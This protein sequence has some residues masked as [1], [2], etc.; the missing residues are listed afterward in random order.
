MINQATERL[1]HDDRCLS[2]EPAIAGNPQLHDI[3]SRKHLTFERLYGRYYLSRLAY[4]KPYVNLYFKQ[5]FP[6]KFSK[7]NLYFKQFFLILTRKSR[8]NSLFSPNRVY[9]DYHYNHA[10]TFVI[11]SLND[12]YNTSIR[13]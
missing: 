9:Y 3:F 12:T 2:G 1:R 8:L 13:P 4:P 10:L 11:V 7:V 5:F 6:Y